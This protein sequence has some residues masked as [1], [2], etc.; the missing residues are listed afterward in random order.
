MAAAGGAALAANQS[1]DTALT[2]SGFVQ[3]LRLRTSV[4]Y[5]LTRVFNDAGFYENALST[6]PAG[7]YVL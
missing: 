6:S 7:R 1:D 5:G 3:R 2:V 4:R